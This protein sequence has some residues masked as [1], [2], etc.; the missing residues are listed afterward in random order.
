MSEIH[1]MSKPPNNNEFPAVS[2]SGSYS[3][4]ESSDRLPQVKDYEIVKK[5]G[6]GGMGIVYLAEQKE[7]I[8]R[9]V[10]LKI[11]KPG[12][13]SAKVIARFEAE[14]QTLALLDH[15]NIARVFEAGTTQLGRPYFSMEYVKGIRITDYCDLKQLNI[16]ERLK[17]FIQV[18]QA[19]QHAHQK[20]F[21]HRDIK[22]SNVLI[23]IQDNQAIPKIIDFGVA[24][25]LSQQLT[26][27]TML[28]EEGQLIG[29]PEYMSPEQ[30][31]LVNQDIDTRSDI[32]SLGVLLYELLTGTLPFDR[33]ALRKAAFGEI[34][35]IIKEEEPP[36]PSTKL[37]SLGDEAT[38]I[39]QNR[40][41][42]LPSLIKRLYK[43]LEWIPLKALRKEPERRYRTMA[44]L[45]DDIRNYLEGAPLIAG[46]ESRMYRIRKFVRRRRALV[47]G[48]TAFVLVLVGGI[49]LST[50]F[51]I[52]QTR[53]RAEADSARTAEVRH[54]QIAEAQRDRAVEAEQ[55]AEQRRAEAE[56]LQIQAQQAS[57]KETVARE[58]AEREAR[59]SKAVVDFL[60]NDLL[61]SVEL[62]RKKGREVTL[63][64]VLDATL[65]TIEGKFQ[66][67]PLIEAAIRTT[68]GIICLRLGEYTKA[69][70]HFER[71]YQIRQQQ[72]GEENLDTITSMSDLAELYRHQGRHDKAGPLHL[73]ALD[74]RRRVQGEEHRDTTTTMN[75]L[76]L[77]YWAQGRHEEAERLNVKV[78]EIRRRTLGEE[79]WVTANTMNNLALVYW[80]QGRH[81]E[82]ERLNVKALEIW[83]RIL[84]EE[85]WDTTTSMNN[86]ALVY[87]AQRRYDEA[88]VL[89]HKAL[90][91]E[92]RVRGEEHPRIIMYMNNLARLYET[93]ERYNE[94]E[95]LYLKAL[96]IE[97]RVRGEEHP[98]AL[99]ATKKLISL[100]DKWG[101][102]EKAEEWRATLPQIET[103]KK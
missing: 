3:E 89:Y 14:R 25:A 7:P 75:N 44:D 90:E 92:L 2:W 16:E 98:H 74:I 24:K 50:V 10:A 9:Q 5:L 63:R 72:L 78:L 52:G 71:A 38:E 12:M 56:A 41:T 42:E 96:E 6:D 27:R 86:L 34:Q 37:S 84:G 102:R 32:Y 69:E 23:S 58:L 46:P 55:L 35:R 64:E 101:R 40:Q 65:E 68:L 19:I 80:A 81:E 30:A 83:Q 82:A 28:T 13:D 48:V 15:P 61:A 97:R 49:V 1:S 29:T 51:A 8:K 20:G 57:Q 103:G 95:P 91:I 93:R 77:V 99:I 17:L 18:C 45:A 33:E 88:E 59:I 60:N 66:D 43:E 31:D 70:P 26:E 36:R 21:I 47:V 94:A 76:A 54:R 22:P 62:A 79:N 39:V 87:E 53:A 73:K 85:H 11:I 100:Y 4:E 67:E